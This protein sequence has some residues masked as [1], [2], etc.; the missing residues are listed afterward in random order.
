MDLSNSKGCKLLCQ[1]QTTQDFLCSLLFL[2]A[3]VQIL[4]IVAPL[5]DQDA[6]AGRAVKDYAK[7]AAMKSN[8]SLLLDRR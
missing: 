5:F 2:Q 7:A 3:Q 1:L 8:D 4:S 6:S